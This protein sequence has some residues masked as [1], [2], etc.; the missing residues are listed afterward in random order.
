MPQ[1]TSYPACPWAA[2]LFQPIVLLPGVARLS[3]PSAP[4][5][6][7]PAETVDVE[8]AHLLGHTWGNLLATL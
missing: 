8:G 2:L 3:L 5:P 1:I 6:R 4:K 7:E